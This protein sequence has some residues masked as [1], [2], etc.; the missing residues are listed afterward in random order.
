MY[1]FERVL[2]IDLGIAKPP[3]HFAFQL[4]RHAAS[5]LFPAQC[6]QPPF[7]GLG[8]QVIV[9]QFLYFHGRCHCAYAESK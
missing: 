1:F 9:L 3:A 5:F 6:P 4:V 8:N 2:C 7:L